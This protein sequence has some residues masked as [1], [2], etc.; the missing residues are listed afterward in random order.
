MIS[1][2]IS[3]TTQIT[4]ALSGII[5]AAVG[6]LLLLAPTAMHQAN[7]V[8]LGDTPSLLSE[9]RAPGGALLALGTL[10]LAGAFVPRLTHPANL[11]AATVY[12]AYGASRLLSLALD[13][14]PAPGLIL[15]MALELALGAANLGL[16]VR[17]G[18]RQPVA[19]RVQTA[20][21]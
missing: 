15:A 19:R 3:K 4:L 18:G 14:L 1:D 13:G 5:L 17:A 16:L 6:G 2:R 8:Q 9:V 21:A 20:R 7:G 10:V 11:I 12:L